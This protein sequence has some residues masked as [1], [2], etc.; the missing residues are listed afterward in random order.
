MIEE[1]RL[2]VNIGSYVIMAFKIK[3][4]LIAG[5]DIHRDI[6]VLTLFYSEQK[7]LDNRRYLCDIK[8][9]KVGIRCARLL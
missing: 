9:L 4:L 8:P 3:G 1:A 6:F 5:F 2:L 7:G